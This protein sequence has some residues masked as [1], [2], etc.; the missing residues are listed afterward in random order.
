MYALKLTLAAMLCYVF[1]NAIAWPGILT[2]VVTV[3]FTG[4]SSTGAMKQ[5][6]LY[7]FAGAAIGGI[8]G[9]ATVSLLFPNM[10]SV[11]ALVGVVAAVA[12]L[13]AWILRSPRIGYVGVQIGFAFFLTT[14]PGFGP[15]T[16]IA[17]ARDRVIGIA[18]GI[19]VMWFIFDQLW[20]VRTSAALKQVLRRIQNSA[21]TLRRALTVGNPAE[22]LQTLMNLRAAVSFEL[23]A[24][25]QL[26]FAAQ[27]EFG[28]GHKRELAASR[29]LVRQIES[30][31]EEFYGQAI[32]M[33]KAA[34]AHPP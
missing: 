34:P 14:L 32:P 25:Q 30:A 29:R 28:Q 18:V 11:T 27:F 23:A 10:D 24:A 5:K 2:C 7:R 21:I 22:A 12:L 31:A 19:L 6:Q 13:S 26:E 33:K 15:A 17:P 20:P 9:I 3:I 8:L 4:L 1:Y 16:L